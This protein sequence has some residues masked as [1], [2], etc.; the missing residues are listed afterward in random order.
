MSAEHKDGAAI[1]RAHSILSPS[2]AAR[3]MACPA[4]PYISKG[5]ESKAGPEAELG[6]RAHELAEL[7]LV[8]K[9][10]AAGR[11]G[12]D[13][14]GAEERI[15][16]ARASLPAEIVQAVDAYTDFVEKLSSSKDGAAIEVEVPLDISAV[17]GEPDAKGTSDCIV[18]TASELWVID[19]KTGRR[20]VPAVGNMQLAIYGMAALLR[21]NVVDQLDLDA[22][23]LVIVQ[24]LTGEEEHVKVWDLNPADLFPGEA[25]ATR[26]LESAKRALAL[27][28]GA[29]EPELEDFCP[30]EKTCLYCPGKFRCPALVGAAR[31][32][33][34]LVPAEAKDGAAA[35]Q[36]IESIPLPTTPE[37]LAKAHQYLP[38]LRQW[39]DAV[40]DKILADLKEGA[41]VP[42]L[43]L[44]EGRQGVRKWGDE[45]KAAAV[46]E[47]ALGVK[48]AYARKLISP[49]EAEKAFKREKEKF[50]ERR[51]HK[52]ERLIVRAAPKPVIAKADDPRPEYGAAIAAEFDDISK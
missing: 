1:V 30:S 34:E 14:T 44:V 17:T 8:H 51:W 48:G 15:E 45:T 46:L 33:A 26:V 4:S 41:A 39:C 36:M 21:L 7:W 27:Y 5:E 32:T 9:D 16:A 52:L 29:A 28:D 35:V 22:V 25:F 12:E 23:H 6:T 20:L 38:I 10:G 50:G 13:Y 43:K 3:W 11:P 19:L 18:R 2:S 37:A 49:T 31:D 42:G 24:P 40:E 47:N